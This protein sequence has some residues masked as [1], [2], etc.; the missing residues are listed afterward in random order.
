M[1]IH[2]IL[3]VQGLH[4]LFLWQHS[5]SRELSIQ[6][7]DKTPHK[8]TFSADR[9]LPRHLLHSMHNAMGQQSNSHQLSL[10]LGIF[11]PVL[12]VV[13][14]QENY[15][16]LWSNVL[17]TQNSPFILFFLWKK[18][19][20]LCTHLPFIWSLKKVKRF[21]LSCPIPSHFYSLLVTNTGSGLFTQ[22]GISVP[23]NYCLCKLQDGDAVA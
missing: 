10:A 21:S 19:I 11:E 13:Q 15:F 8:P 16:L 9:Q 12:K 5:W 22:K 6:N 14:E 2:V 23:K 18:S 4:L 20:L 17:E 3:F 7:S 1:N